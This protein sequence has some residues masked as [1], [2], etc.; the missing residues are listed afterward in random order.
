M[1]PLGGAIVRAQMSREALGGAEDVKY[2]SESVSPIAYWCSGFSS[3]VIQS[4]VKVF[5]YAHWDF[6]E[7]CNHIDRP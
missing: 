4:T 3:S 1:A 6:S 2:D 5:L 7:D